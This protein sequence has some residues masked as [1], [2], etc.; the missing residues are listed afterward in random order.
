MNNDSSQ[1]IELKDQEVVAVQ[2]IYLVWPGFGYTDVLKR[3]L[4]EN[5]RNAIM[6]TESASESFKEL[7]KTWEGQDYED[8]SPFKPLDTTFNPNYIGAIGVPNP[9]KFLLFDRPKGP[10]GIESVRKAVKEIVAGCLWIFLCNII[11]LRT[12]SSPVTD[13]Y[14]LLR[15]P[16]AQEG[17][18]FA[19]KWVYGCFVKNVVLH[20]Y[21]SVEQFMDVLK[22]MID[23][24]HGY[25]SLVNLG[26]N[27]QIIQKILPD[28]KDVLILAEMSLIFD[29][30]IPSPNTIFGLHMSDWLD[31]DGAQVWSFKDRIAA[32]NIVYDIDT[33]KFLKYRPDDR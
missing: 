31:L 28:D 11:P 8:N 20:H 13:L 3:V 7:L 10:V 4:P 17:L 14:S 25:G 6:K 30:D 21:N 26:F 18:T 2:S 5:Y 24:G 32:H 19:G 23:E 16:Q 12:K 22:G 29:E 27:R 15:D 9:G 1:R 33:E